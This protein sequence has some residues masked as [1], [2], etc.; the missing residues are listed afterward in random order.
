MVVDQSCDFQ[1]KGKA[2]QL[3]ERA[4]LT[5]ELIATV[6]PGT[7]PKELL[8]ESSVCDSLIIYCTLS[9]EKAVV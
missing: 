6:G 9:S 7:Q 4:N 2:N 5:W 8:T 1:N 3:C